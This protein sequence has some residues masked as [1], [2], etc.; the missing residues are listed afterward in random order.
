[1]K[2]IEVTKNDWQRRDRHHT[3]EHQS[4]MI[5]ED[6][7]LI[8]ENKNILAAQIRMTDE[9]KEARRLLTRHLRFHM[10]WTTETKRPTTGQR[11]SGI[12][13]PNRTFGYTAPAPLRGRY[14]AATSSIFRDQP[15]VLML[16]DSLTS[17]IWKLFQ[18][19]LPEQAK[20]HEQLF[21]NEVHKD[22]W[23]ANS[24][25]TSG[26]I[27]KTAALPYHKDSG[28]IQNTWSAML[29]LRHNVDGGGLHLPEYN[30]TLGI[31]HNSVTF[32]DGQNTWHGVTPF[33]F[34]KAEAYRFT[35]VWYGKNGFK[36]CGFK[37]THIQLA[38]KKATL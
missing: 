17:D 30:V 10:K 12:K 33:V 24:P 9:L 5:E 37:A 7:V 4:T 6:C 18:T 35:I 23:F 8:D 11:A 34:K 25:W 20:M 31:P 27:N 22:W 21:A 29:G 19:H 16:L 3:A 38:Q 15:D 36:N 32:F 2:I 28:N 13:Y 1:M 14:G 26:I